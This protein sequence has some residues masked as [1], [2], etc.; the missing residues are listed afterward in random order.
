MMAPPNADHCESIML[1]T[2]SPRRRWPQTLRL[3]A[4]RPRANATLRVAVVGLSAAVVATLDQAL[5]LASCQA[6]IDFE[7]SDE[8]SHVALVDAHLAADL[9]DDEWR[10]LFGQRPVVAVSEPGQQV[11]QTRTPYQM[12]SRFDDGELLSTLNSIPEVRL[13]GARQQARTPLAGELLA[14]AP[15]IVVELLRRYDDA[16]APFLL[17][18]YGDGPSM[19]IDFARAEVMADPQAWERVQAQRELPRSADGAF[20][21]AGLSHG[22]KAQRLESLVW[23]VGLACAELPL[24]NA[25]AAWREARL[26][27]QGWLHL[28]AFSRMP[29]HLHMAERLAQ[30]DTTPAELRRSTRVDE[31][32]LRAFV[33]AGL[34]LNLLHWA[35]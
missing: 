10:T 1:Q 34:F 19:L 23:A 7:L 3:A 25:P 20:A 2:M 33:Q 31:A 4:R 26:A 12:S 9:N 8:R 11:A 35:R 21:P 30:G 29:V 17:A 16:G 5:K 28:K 6:P 14:A 15:P 18:G 27:S 32:E 22:A 13:R 24:H